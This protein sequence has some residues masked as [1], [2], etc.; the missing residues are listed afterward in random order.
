MKL[1]DKDWTKRGEWPEMVIR[2]E[3]VFITLLPNQILHGSV[4]VGDH[5]FV[6]QHTCHLDDREIKHISIF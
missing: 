1:G 5:Y 4:L 6:A 2:A 3:E